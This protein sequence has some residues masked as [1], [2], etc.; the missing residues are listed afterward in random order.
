MLLPGYHHDHIFVP[1]KS[2]NKA[3]RALQQLSNG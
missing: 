2:G 1:F 3:L